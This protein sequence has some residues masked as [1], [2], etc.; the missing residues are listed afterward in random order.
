LDLSPSP[1]RGPA[2]DVFN[3]GGGQCGTYRQHLPGGPPSTSSTSVVAA[4]GTVASTPRE[5]AI[6]VFNIGGGRS[7]IDVFTSR[8]PTAAIDVSKR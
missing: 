3:F 5:T 1:P 6:D 8:G 4:V 7:T 2:I